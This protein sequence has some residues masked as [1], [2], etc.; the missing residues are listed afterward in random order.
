MWDGRK[1]RA[2]HPRNG[3]TSCSSS[4]PDTSSWLKSAMQRRKFS[5][6]SWLFSTL[7][8]C[9]NTENRRL[10]TL[11]Q[12][13]Y[14]L[15]YALQMPCVRAG[16]GC[17]GELSSLCCPLPSTTVALLPDPVIRKQLCLKGSALAHLIKEGELLQGA[18]LP[19]SS[20]GQVF[21]APE[22]HLLLQRETLS[23]MVNPCHRQCGVHGTRGSTKCSWQGPV[24][25]TLGEVCCPALRC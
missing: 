8:T 20:N 17:S 9:G 25:R 16:R 15:L 5:Y 1:P 6:T 10:E 3:L 12:K 21:G 24:P 19:H 4:E 14:A 7:R 11:P 2:T 22:L 13:L 18:V 23:L